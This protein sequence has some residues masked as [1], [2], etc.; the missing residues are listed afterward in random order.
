MQQRLLA[1]LKSFTATK[2]KFKQRRLPEFGKIFVEFNVHTGVAAVLY[3]PVVSARVSYD[4]QMD[5]N[6]WGP[7]QLVLCFGV[8]N[9]D[10]AVSGC[11]LISWCWWA[12]DDCM[13]V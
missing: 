3:T 2:W 4:Y 7:H 11:W 12:H 13:P 9:R 6:V 8:N 10:L 5:Y 1:L